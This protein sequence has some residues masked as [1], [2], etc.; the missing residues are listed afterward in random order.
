LRSA[1]RGGR[2]GGVWVPPSGAERGGRPPAVKIG[3][4]RV[5]G[6]QFW[7]GVREHRHAF[8]DGPH[9]LWRVAVPSVCPPLGA[10]GDSLIEWG[11]ALRWLRG[12]DARALGAKAGGHATL[13][14]SPR[15]RGGVF[16]ALD[17]V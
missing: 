5:E 1:P 17:P 10:S 16:A 15:K 8:F 7:E 11:G 2:G 12:A 9:P 14:R 13:F 3:G 4:A 6:G